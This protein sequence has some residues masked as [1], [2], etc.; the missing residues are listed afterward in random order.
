MSVSLPG[1]GLTPYGIF[2]HGQSFEEAADIVMVHYKNP[3]SDHPARLLYLHAIETFLRAYLRLQGFEP[4]EIRAY[5]HDLARMV[6]DAVARGL[7]L[8]KKSSAYI[9]GAGSERDYVR[10]RYD[11]D[12]RDLSGVWP[13]PAPA[14]P[15]TMAALI[16]AAG[17]V[18]IAVRD[19]LRATGV[20]IFDSFE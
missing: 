8:D 11:Y 7:K 5:Q 17:N 3:S 20:E 10:V 13:P 1:A 9:R 16:S 6:D 15:K 4:G 12:L 18:R 14:R 2:I 19:A